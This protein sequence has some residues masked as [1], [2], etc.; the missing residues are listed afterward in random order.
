MQLPFDLTMQIKS[1]ITQMMH[2]SCNDILLSIEKVLQSGS[3]SENDVAEI[4]G[5]YSFV[6]AKLLIT[7][8]FNKQPYAPISD[9]HKR[10]L[11]NLEYFI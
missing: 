5:E 7:A 1:Q 11:K 3:L 9:N 4:T 10:I 2:T 8:Y 6:F